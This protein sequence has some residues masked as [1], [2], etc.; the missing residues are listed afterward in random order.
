MVW[1]KI[2]KREVKRELRIAEREHVG[3]QIKNNLRVFLRNQLTER[4]ILKTKK[5]L[6]MSFILS[7]HQSDKTLLKT[8]RL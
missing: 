7:L 1:Y 4:H 2:L 6:Q 3:E 5:R 8:L